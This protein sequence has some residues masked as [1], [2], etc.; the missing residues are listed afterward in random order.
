M[1]SVSIKRVYDKPADTDGTRILVD[2]LWPRGVSKRKAALDGWNKDVAPSTDLRKWFGH[3]PERFVEFRKRY[4]AELKD[5]PAITALR[6][7]KGKLTLLYGAKDPKINH[8]IVLAAML[9]RR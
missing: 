5:S 3:K 2:R 6:A 1:R 8:A 9:R 7:T 4:R